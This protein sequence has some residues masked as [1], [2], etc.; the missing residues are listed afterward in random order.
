MTLAAAAARLVRQLSGAAGHAAMPDRV[1]AEIAVE[2]HRGDVLVSIVQV[3]LCAIFVLLYAL[4]RKT[5]PADAPFTPVPWALALYAVFSLAK[6]AAA[7]RA[8]LPDWVQVLSIVADMA[9]L[10]GLIW[11]FHLQYDQPPAFYLKA[12]TLLY[13][14]I[15]IALRALRFDARFVL[16]AGG[17]AA[18]GWLGLAL[19]A[20]FADP[21]GMPLTRDFRVYMNSPMLLWGA[22]IDKMISILLVTGLIALSIVR[23]RHM[24]FRAVV[25]RAAARDLARFFAPE[26]AQRIVGAERAIRAGEGEIRQAAAMFVDLRGFTALSRALDA[27]ALVMLLTEYQARLVPAIGRNGGS[28]DKFMGDGIMASF[29]AMS[30]DP[31]YA[32]NA[33]AAVDDLM[34]QADIWIEECR[35]RG[36]PVTGV[37]VAVASG[38]VLVGAVGDSTRLEY[39]V[40]GETVNLAAKLEK[41]TK[42]EKVRALADAA[43]YDLARAQGYARELERRRSS[44]A[45]VE[46]P[47]DLVVLA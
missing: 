47:V 37:G 43:T 8:R 41:H 38:P 13:V 35:A 25:E 14:F 28:V 5:H 21:G 10:L 40:I 3:A 31:A 46:G 23:A 33:L 4:S 44:V 32:A 30:D 11:S 36:L 29:G 15:F 6:L 16:L 18:L 9:L 26:I 1:R 19:Y 34:A 39:T 12:P 24:L 27:N 22:E 45:G 42:T 7:W 17:V 20:A 2:Q